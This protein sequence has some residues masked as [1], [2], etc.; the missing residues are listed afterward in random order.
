MVYDLVFHKKLILWLLREIKIEKYSPIFKIV[1]SSVAPPVEYPVTIYDY[2]AFEMLLV[3]IEMFVSGKY[4]L[5]FN[6]LV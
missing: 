1:K 5:D 4:I 3:Q 2:W 6:D